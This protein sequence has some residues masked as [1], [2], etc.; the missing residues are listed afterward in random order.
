[1]S[2]RLSKRKVIGQQCRICARVELRVIQN[3]E[4]KGHIWRYLKAAVRTKLV[5]DV[6]PH[7]LNLAYYSPTRQDK[8]V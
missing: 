4:S 3:L 2:K 1:M 6:N 7:E 5:D 8:Q